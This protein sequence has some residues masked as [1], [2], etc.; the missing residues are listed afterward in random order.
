MIGVIEKTD[1]FGQR[2]KFDICGCDYDSLIFQET[3]LN[4]HA[5]HY[6]TGNSFRLIE[7]IEFGIRHCAYSGVILTT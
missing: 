6:G 3:E 2:T 4:S 1:S 5:R 7:W